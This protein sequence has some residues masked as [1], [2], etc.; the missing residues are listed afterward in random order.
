MKD[1]QVFGIA[2]GLKKPWHV[3]STDL[4]ADR[5]RLDIRVDFTSRS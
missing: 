2:L 3:E 5:I 1:I 4:D